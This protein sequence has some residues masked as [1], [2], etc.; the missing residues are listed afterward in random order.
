MSD[1]KARSEAPVEN[2]EKNDTARFLNLGV[3]V[4][5]SFG[6]F[7][8]RELDVVSLGMLATNGLDVLVQMQ[9]QET[10]TGS[11]F[12][13][14]N[15]VLMSPDG[16]DIIARIFALYCGEEDPTPFKKLKPK[17]FNA[18]WKAAKEVT[19]FEEIKETFF[20]LGLQKFLPILP[21]STDQEETAN[22]TG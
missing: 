21:T 11:D 12:A 15:R 16:R 8:V 3:P 19:D 17:D 7:T 20:V 13:L 1:P 4:K 6:E 22:P 5:L 2:N 10:S 18:L 9:Q 14:I